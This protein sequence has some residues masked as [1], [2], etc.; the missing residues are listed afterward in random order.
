MA[1]AGYDPRP[2]SHF[3]GKNV[4]NLGKLPGISSPPRYLTLEI[5]KLISKS[6]GDECID[7]AVS[8]QSIK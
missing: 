1:I 5:Q 8:R 7:E 3:F 6:K 2:A 4:R